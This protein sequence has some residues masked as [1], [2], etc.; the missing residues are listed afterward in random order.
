MT[1]SYRHANPSVTT[2][3]RALDLGSS[4]AEHDQLLQQHFVE[5]QT[6]KMLLESKV[7]IVAGDKGTGKTAIFRILK[8]RYASYEQLNDVE[9]VAAFNPAGTP[10]FQR[11]IETEVLAEE[12]YIGVWKAYFLSLAGNWVLNLGD[13]DFSDSMRELDKL[14]VSVGLRSADET[15]QTIFS[16]VVNR[17]KRLF[18]VTSVENTP[19]LSADGMPVLGAKVDFS[20]SGGD[21]TVVTDLVRQDDALQLLQKVLGE[22]DFKLWLVVDRLDEAFQARPALERPALRAL[23]RTYLDMLDLSNVRIK[24]F[25]R[26]DLFSRI[27]EGGFVNLTH[28][29]ARRVDITWDDDDLFT[30][31]DRRFRGSTE[32]VNYLDAEDLEPADVFNRVFPSQVDPGDRKPVTWT[33]ILGRIRDGNGV[34]PPRNLIDL[35]LKAQQAQ[36]RQEDRSPRRMSTKESLITSD[37]LKRGLEALSAERVQDTLLAEAGDNAALIELFRGGKAEHNASSLRQILGEEY[38]PKISL[39]KTIGFL[40]QVGSNYKVPML[41]RGGLSI[42]QG[43]AFGNELESD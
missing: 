23:L 36:I 1:Q 41:Y 28:I 38:E 43:K 37:A 8:E 35:V 9:V 13:G 2:V 18:R 3:L 27:I 39:L 31:L 5:T 29:N 24:L 25:V 42:T 4:V 34:K 33:W 30:L 16:Q 19:S 20:E 22:L 17:L 11:L 6:F 12:Q 10:V 26:R 32:F 21:D 14:L 15:P 40:E 7:D